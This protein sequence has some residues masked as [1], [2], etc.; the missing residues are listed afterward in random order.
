MGLAVRNV[1]EYLRGLAHLLHYSNCPALAVQWLLLFRAR[2]SS[3]SGAALPCLGTDVEAE[4]AL[5]ACESRHVP[6]AAVRLG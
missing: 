3:L 2:A 1:L 5:D 6:R 4:L